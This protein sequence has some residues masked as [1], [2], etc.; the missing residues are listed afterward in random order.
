MLNVFRMF[1]MMGARR[2]AVES[3]GMLPLETMRKVGVRT[4]A[5]VGALASKND[6]RI[7]TMVWHYHDDELPGPDA[8]V[9]LA[10]SGL[11]ATAKRALVKHYR[12]DREHSNS[13]EAWKAMGSPAN[14]SPEQY[15]QLE[16]GRGAE[17]GRLALVHRREVGESRAEFCL[18]R[19]KAFR[20]W[21]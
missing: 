5:D 20:L 12:I 21:K 3:S 18:C 1:G 7:T 10:L 11:G 8:A 15:A 13:Y 19:G 2:V 17:D 4:Q 9:H 14:V 6:R 16:K